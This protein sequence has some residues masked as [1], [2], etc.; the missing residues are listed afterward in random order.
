MSKIFYREANT[1]VTKE[2]KSRQYRYGARSRAGQF[3]KGEGNSFVGAKT[4]YAR[5]QSINAPKDEFLGYKR[6]GF[7][8]VYSVNSK[9]DNIK[10]RPVL[11]SVNIRQDGDIGT[12]QKCTVTWKVFS[13]HQ[14]E[15]YNCNFLSVGT[16]VEI[17]YGWSAAQND[18]NRG[19]FVGVVYNINYNLDKDG[20]FICSFEA[21]G[22]GF[23]TLG[24][25]PTSFSVD[26]TAAAATPAV[27]GPP[28]VL[29]NGIAGS[30]AV[31]RPA[32][33]G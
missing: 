13:I 28:V 2:I 23:N 7:E 11:T 9:G 22:P 3:D 25:D 33:L 6:K 26:A 18:A 4:A 27:D 19:T 12:I 31:D 16:D 1:D 30:F 17:K 14:L 21:V 15:Q 10:P 8:S 29:Y 5:V 20:G 32:I 24:M